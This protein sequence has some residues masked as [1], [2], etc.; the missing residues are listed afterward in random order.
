MKV[1]EVKH[2]NVSYHKDR[3]LENISF[4]VNQKDFPRY[5]WT[6]WLR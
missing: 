1:F 4:G 5:F 3:V 2:L 6:K